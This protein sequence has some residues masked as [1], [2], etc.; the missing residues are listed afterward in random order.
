MKIMMMFLLIF[1][2]SVLAG[3]NADDITGLWLSEEKTGV[4]KVSKE[5]DE[6]V[7]HLVWIKKIA[8][9]EKKDVL[10]DKNPDKKL[11]S[12]SIQNL[13]ML[14][15]FKFE[16]DEWSGGRI[17]DP[18]TGKTYKA[19]MALKN[20]KTLKLRGYVGISLFGRSSYWTRLDKLP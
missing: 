10:D 14:Y 3:V 5:G 6:F 18:K 20:E 7:G 8:T 9:G 2:S 12:R 17:Y 15:G 11:R 4:I 19:Y 13:K 1:S 16:D